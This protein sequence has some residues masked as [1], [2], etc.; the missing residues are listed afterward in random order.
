VSAAEWSGH[1][2]DLIERLRRR[3]AGDAW[4]FF[5][6]VPDGT[7]W[8]KSRTLDAIAMSLWASRG[9]ELHGFEVKVQ[10]S[11]W[12]REL[13]SAAKSDDFVA[14]CDR[15]WL[16]APRSIVQDGELPP[17]WGLIV[18]RGAGLAVEVAAPK[19]EAAAVDRAFLASLCRQVHRR[20]PQVEAIAAAR[21]EGRDEGYKAGVER[22]KREASQSERALAELQRGLELFEQASGVRVRGTWEAGRIGEAVRT[23]LSLAGSGG[24]AGLVERVREELRSALRRLEGV[25]PVVDLPE[26]P[27]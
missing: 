5:A 23:V 8:A 12:L 18:P 16:V 11:D 15:F 7:G 9:L 10:R 3:H 4:A 6:E 13:R 17:T 25:D 24:A 27:L 26:Q 21:R 19:L 22:G 2:G 14:Y 1:A 20:H